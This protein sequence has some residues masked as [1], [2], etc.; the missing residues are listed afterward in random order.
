MGSLVTA[1]KGKFSPAV[2]K[3]VLKLSMGTGLYLKSTLRSAGEKL[4]D[5]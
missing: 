1:Q 4:T 5:V 3:G 2:K